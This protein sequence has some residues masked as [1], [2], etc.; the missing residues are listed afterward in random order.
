[1]TLTF[2]D[3]GVLI[4]AVRG[5]PAIARTAIEILDDDQRTF[6]SS[7]FVRLEVLPKPLFHR[8]TEESA[9]YEAFFAAVTDWARWDDSL[10]QEAF[11]LASRSGLSALDAL[12]AA[13]AISVGA[14]EI[15]TT[16]KAGRP[17]HRISELHIR[18]IH[19]G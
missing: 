15:V 9:F 10:L 5:T 2:I 19:P 8:K 7:D 16:E 4:A 17:I 18:T 14:D 13:A 12:H 11:S 6:A 3:A 1:L